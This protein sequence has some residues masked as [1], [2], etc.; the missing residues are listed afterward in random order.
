MA[1]S[2]VQAKP[3]SGRKVPTKARSV[4]VVVPV[5]NEYESLRSLRNALRQVSKD[6][7]QIGPL[8]IIFV[9]DGSTDGS[10][11]IIAKMAKED[12]DVTSIR[13]RRNFGKAAALDIGVREA[14][15]EI[16][17]TMD[18]DLQDDPI[19][20]PNFLRKLDEG[21]DVVSGWKEVRKDRTEKTLSLIHI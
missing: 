6:T 16:I 20:I 21:Y 11:Q 17:I 2:S 13:L 9:D 12:P 14:K 1:E 19:E 18:A 8:H 5:Y 15:S 10:W 7:P 4:S 3:G